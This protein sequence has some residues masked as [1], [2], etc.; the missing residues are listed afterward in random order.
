MEDGNIIRSR[1]NRRLK[2]VRR[3]RDSRE[4]NAIF[5]EGTRLAYEAIR[6]DI[7]IHEAY[8]S[9]A[10]TKNDRNSGCH[11]RLAQRGAV[12]FEVADSIF[13]SIADTKTSQGI[14]IIAARPKVGQEGIEENLRNG[15]CVARLVVYLH[16]INNP[17]NLGAII[18]I[19]EAAGISGI[20]LSERSADPFSPKAIR[21][22][23]GSAFRVPV[24][25]NVRLGPACEWARRNGLRI[26]TASACSG[27]SYSEID[28]TQPK[29]LVFGSEAW[30]LK[31]FVPDADTDSIMIPM[32]NAVESLNLAVSC[33]II[34]FEAC[35]Q[36]QSGAGG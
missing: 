27:M 33:G 22:S 20:I 15:S 34:L 29:F 2:F 21:G 9:Q 12:I 26:T 31:D 1:E 3:V 25:Q 8:V 4:P 32:K 10:F 7:E 28:W 19:V 24:W 16:E 30:G 23:M 35:R 17:L 13:A 36:N 18:R 6:S 14:V 5:V 11:D